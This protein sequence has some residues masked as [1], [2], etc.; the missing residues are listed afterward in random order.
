MKTQRQPL[1]SLKTTRDNTP[2][3]ASRMLGEDAGS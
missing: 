3:P 1:K 2:M